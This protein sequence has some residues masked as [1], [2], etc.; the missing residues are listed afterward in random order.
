MSEVTVAAATQPPTPPPPPPAAEPTEAP[1]QPAVET[2]EQK[3]DD[4]SATSKQQELDSEKE[5]K[6]L[7]RIM[8]R[9][10]RRYGEE[11]ARRELLEAEL[12]KFKSQAEP[13]AAPL[14]GEPRLEQFDDIEK[15]AEAKAEWRK[16][17]ALKEYEQRQRENSNKER[18]QRISKDWEERIATAS[19]KYDDFEDVVGEIKPVNPISVAIMRAENGPDVAY[20]LAKNQK[21]AV[22]LLSLEPM[23]QVIE[24][25]RLSAKLALQPPVAK[26]PSKAPPPITPVSGTSA[27]GPEAELADA[28][29]KKYIAL[30]NKQLGRRRQ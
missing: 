6:R 18:T 30:R 2:T 8:D 3:P 17:Q 26:E 9:A 12:Q 23:D 24:I 5:R 20:H 14:Q 15:Y 16:T 19:E 27:A 28:D 10:N 25:G 13:K 11:K 4:A 7:Q 1:A 21:E 22:R 29:M